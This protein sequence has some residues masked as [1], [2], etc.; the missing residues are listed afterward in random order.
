MAS[1]IC[2]THSHICWDLATVSATTTQ[3]YT[4]VTVLDDDNKP[5]GK[6]AIPE[7]PDKITFTRLLESGAISSAIFRAGLPASNG[8]QQFLWEIDGGDGSIRLES[9]EIASFF[10][11]VRIARW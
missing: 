5:T 7:G 11:N 10:I 6:T 4:S 8:R 1:A 3:H 9:D 2:S